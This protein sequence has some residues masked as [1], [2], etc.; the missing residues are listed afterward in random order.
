MSAL[1]P[2]RRA[3]QWAV[4]LLFLGVPLLNATGNHIVSGNL[5]SFSAGPL[6]LADPLA[7]LQ[8]CA[9]A[10]SGT[11]TMLWAAGLTLLAAA[12]LGPVFCSWI[13]PYGLFSELACKAL[14]RGR[15]NTPGARP[16]LAFHAFAVKTGI[17][18]AGFLTIALYPS[19]WLN[20]LSMPGWC[21]RVPQH[22]VLYREILWGAGLVLSVLTVEVLAGRRL[23]CRYI[24]PQSVL[25][26]LAGMLLPARLRIRFNPKA[27]TCGKANPCA[28]ACSLFLNPRSGG[29]AQRLQCTNCGDCVNACRKKGN[30]L[31]FVC[32]SATST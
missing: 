11:P 7:V 16:R 25:V 19:P 30:A 28:S 23:W 13:C 22:V 3:T 4:V 9:G 20:Q 1:S 17:V 24:C 15:N 10:L 6:T 2:L 18:C 8:A 12:V 31:S 21:T 32:G 29:A 26:C 27:C 5:F 14:R